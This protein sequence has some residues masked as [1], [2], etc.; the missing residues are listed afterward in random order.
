MTVVQGAI[1]SLPIATSAAVKVGTVFEI[2][3]SV[4]DPGNVGRRFSVTGI[5]AQ[6]HAT[7]RR[8]QVE[9]YS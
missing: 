5:H 7:A 8:F 3:A 2:V 9:H 1:L 4:S 6:T